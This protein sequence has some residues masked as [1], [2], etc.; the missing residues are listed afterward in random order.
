MANLSGN[1]TGMAATTLL[2]LAVTT[3]GAVV[4]AVARIFA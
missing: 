2:S 1:V 4:E 3:N